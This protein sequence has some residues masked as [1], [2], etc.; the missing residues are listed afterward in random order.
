ML[1]SP[2]RTRHNRQD[3]K[4][5]KKVICTIQRKLVSG[6]FSAIL[7]CFS[8]D[9]FFFWLVDLQVQNYYP[10]T[11]MMAIDFVISYMNLTIQTLLLN[12]IINLGTKLKHSLSI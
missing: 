1:E 2:C 6:T 10:T 12:S 9:F 11:F 4:T 3:D 8:A 7:F 5:Y